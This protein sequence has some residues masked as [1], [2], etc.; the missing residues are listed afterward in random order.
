MAGFPRAGSSLLMN[1]LA[2]NPAFFCTPT[3]GL[4]GSV[5]SVRDN[6]RNSDVYKAN[7]EDYV[8]PKIRTML[9]GMIEGF[10]N[11][12]L[13]EGKTPIDKNRA[14]TGHLDL[15]DEIFDTRVKFIFPIRHIVD[16]CISMEKSNR[17][18]TLTTHGDNGNWINERTTKGRCENFIK[19][20]GVLGLPIL[21]LRE[22]IYRNQQKRLILV[23]YN[24]LLTYPNETLNK[25]Y[26]ELGMDRFKHDFNSIKQ[27]IVEYD[28][29]HGFAPNSLHKI[30]EGS[31]NELK[32]RDMT[33]FDRQ[34]MENI[35][36]NR[37]GD[38]TY[39]INNNS[40]SN[41]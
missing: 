7:G 31:L 37:F 3:S 2:Q 36:N 10:Y 21:H 34:Y 16:C 41:K 27:V 23:P 30:T 32:P 4:V 8:Y 25:L 33:I 39:F 35:E 28:L 9:K 24:D 18:S 15:M 13:T 19:E 22:I 20:D 5:I 38:I 14:W 26:N 40:L 11:K 1:I 29:F 12:E 6:W 17:I